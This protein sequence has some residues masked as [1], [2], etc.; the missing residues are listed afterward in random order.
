MTFFFVLSSDEFGKPHSH[1]RQ[2]NYLISLTLRYCKLVLVL[3][4]LAFINQESVKEKECP[5]ERLEYKNKHA[6]LDMYSVI[7]VIW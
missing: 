5:H 3:K 2:E 1:S 6:I 4:I 7:F